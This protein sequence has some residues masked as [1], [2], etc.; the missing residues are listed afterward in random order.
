MCIIVV[1]VEA[2]FSCSGNGKWPKESHLTHE[3]L[4]ILRLLNK[5]PQ[6]LFIS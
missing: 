4:R 3:A 2:A 6:L 5:I 1:V